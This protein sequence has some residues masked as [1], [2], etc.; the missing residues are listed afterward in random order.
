MLNAFLSNTFKNSWYF[1]E[2]TSLIIV[3]DLLCFSKCFSTF[4]NVIENKLTFFLL[5]IMLNASASIIA[6]F[7]SNND[8]LSFELKISSSL[9]LSLKALI[10]FDSSSLLINFSRFLSFR[11]RLIVDWSD[12]ISFREKTLVTIIENFLEF[13]M[14]MSNLTCSDWL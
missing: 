10:F 1:D 4:F 11:K 12:L 2:K 6:M 7:I 14:R 5:L 3:S 8:F 9:R 13:L